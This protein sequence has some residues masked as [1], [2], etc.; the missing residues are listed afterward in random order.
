MSATW[1]RIIA[2]FTRSVTSDTADILHS[3]TVPSFIPLSKVS[4]I[5]RVDDKDQ[6]VQFQTMR[7]VTSSTH[8]L[9]TIV[10]LVLLNLPKDEH[11]DESNAFPSYFVYL[12]DINI[13]TPSEFTETEANE[14]KR[15]VWCLLHPC[16]RERMERH[17]SG[18]DS[19]IYDLVHE[20]RYNP[21]VGVDPEKSEA[22]AHF[23][24]EK[25]QKK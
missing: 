4:H 14:Q 1:V 23:L 18:T 2:S 20:L 17:L 6:L 11:D 21:H 25:R 3:N 13:A 7:R 10:N 12:E 8:W 15:G 22:A 16:E 19:P 5:R 24:E 9:Q